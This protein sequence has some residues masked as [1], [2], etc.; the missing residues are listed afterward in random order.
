MHIPD[1]VLS[2]PVWAA[3]DL[4]LVPAVAVAAKDAR[5]HFAEGRTPLLGA[6]G[7]FVFAAQLINFPV[8]AGTSSHLLGG[9]LLAVTVGPCA[10]TL[11]LTAILLLQALLFQDGGILALGANAINMAVAGVWLGYLPYRQ[12]AKA[13]HAKL[14][15][16]VGSLLSVLVGAGLMLLELSLSGHTF[17][18]ELVGLSA[19]GFFLTA[20]VEGFITMSVVA[21]L[22][23]VQPQLLRHFS[24]AASSGLNQPPARRPLL[25]GLLATSA[26]LAG[27]AVLFASSLPD[28]FEWLAVN[29]GFAAHATTLFTTPFTDYEWSLFASEW[30][31]KASAGLLG[32]AAI[33][34][35]CL[36]VGRLVWRRPGV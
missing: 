35:L 12:L 28:G 7:A 19:L 3:L 21:A 31:R 27:V 34:G 26:T 20:L 18:A 9:M 17:R 10:A 22:A 36:A 30:P 15:V 32:I 16:L 2:V 13:G 8:G 33:Y 25:L 29:S 6:L 23:K 14:G 24:P 5:A 4:A 1:G 11:V